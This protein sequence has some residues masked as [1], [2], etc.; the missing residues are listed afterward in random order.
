LLAANHNEEIR[1]LDSSRRR[2]VI[3]GNGIAGTGCAETLRKNDPDCQ[4]TLF[5]EEPYP[6]YNRV[7]LPPFL[8]LQAT[9]T[10]V[11]M[12]NRERHEQNRIDLR[13][14]TRVEHICPEERTVTT[15]S[16]EEVPYDALLIATGG[17]PNP[18][19]VPGGHLH[20]VYNF[21]TLDDSKAINER[22]LEARAAV[23]IGGSYIAYE[24]TEAF[25]SRGLDTTW[26]MRG[27]RFLRRVLDA[28]GGRIVD[29]IAADHGVRVIHGEEIAEIHGKD[30]VI[31]S[32]TT[33]GGH[34][35]DADILGVGLGLTLNTAFVKDSGLELHG[36]IVT[37]EKLR[38]NL[39]GIYAAGDVAIFYDT[40]IDAHSQMGTWDNSSSQG[41]L[42]ARNMAGADETYVEVPTYTTTM[43][44]SKLRVVGITSEVSPE[45]DAISKSNWD[46]RSYARLFFLHDRLVGAVAIGELR[47]RK[48]LLTLIKTKERLAEPAA[49][50]ALL[51][52]C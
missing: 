49:R 52:A 11:L 34:T 28:E 45:V 44:H 23:T 14:E 25:R 41:R 40:F 2:Y 15:H 4:I 39:P 16:G 27:P 50:Q 24:L 1:L 48:D 32:V 13:L 37:D 9:E 35:L 18:I 29:A 3:I 17:R 19:A 43:F 8:K 33:M 5:A 31:T 38:T 51:Q 46:E 12:R 36:G 20:G 7:S 10:K 6:L 30:G 42:V 26:I 47:N 22:I 21:Q